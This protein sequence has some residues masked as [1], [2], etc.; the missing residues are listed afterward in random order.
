LLV[1]LA[2]SEAFSVDLIESVAFSRDFAVSVFATVDLSV[3][4]ALSVIYAFAPVL[5]ELSLFCKKLN[6]SC[7]SSD[8]VSGFDSVLGLG[9]SSGSF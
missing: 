8:Y 2:E 4:V 6:S 9:F 3:T 5:R 7:S 1:D